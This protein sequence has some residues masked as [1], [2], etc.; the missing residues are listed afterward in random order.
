ML[1]Y[2]YKIKVYRY[3]KVSY[4]KG[5]INRFS[6]ICIELKTGSVLKNRRTL[7]LRLKKYN[8]K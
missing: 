8:E 6:R 7:L 5:P 1:L 3:V 4:D 2:A